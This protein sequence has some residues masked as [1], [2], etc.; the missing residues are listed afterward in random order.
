MSKIGRAVI[1]IMEKKA[2]LG[3]DVENLTNDD[4]MAELEAK[5]E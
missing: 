2:D 4:L 3:E 5:D 1:D